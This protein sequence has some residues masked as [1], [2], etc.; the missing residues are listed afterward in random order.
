MNRLKALI[1]DGTALFRGVGSRLMEQTGFDVTIAETGSDGLQL[2]KSKK[3]DLIC[4]SYHL[5][6]MSGSEFCGQIRALSRYDFSPVLMLTGEDNP[7]ILKQALLSGA[8]DIFYK[9]DLFELENYLRRFVERQSRKLSGRVLFIED[10]R[11]LQEIMLDLLTDMGLDV[12]AYTHAEGA[13]Q[14]FE[15]SHYDLVI[16]D[17]MLEGAMSGI[18]LV[19]KIR[20]LHSE[21]GDVPIIAVSG[22][23]NVS[24]KIELFNLGVN[25]YVAKPIIH[26][27][28]KQRVFNNV[29]S[30]QAVLELRS[31]QKA[32]YSLA[33]L[34]ELTQ[35][36][37]RHA[38]REFSSKYFS[39]AI[40]FNR[41]LTMAVMDIDSFKEINRTQGHDKG[42]KVLAELGRWLKRFVRDEDMVA[43][44]SGDE[45]IFL[46]PDCDTETASALMKRLQKRL[47][48]FKPENIE[49]TVSI[50]IA[51]TQGQEN[52]NLNSLFELADGAMYQAKMAGRNCVREYHRDTDSLETDS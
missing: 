12:D 29:T 48:Q 50:G 8:T 44:W 14:A 3:F 31:Q 42:D 40:R 25:D 28:I 1:I 43:R 16:T 38:L 39:E 34:D 19:R 5:P 26:E 45:F 30:Y 10:S 32:L 4:C 46:L 24:R 21:R 18:S 27:E 20:R 13:W 2:A 36:F 49:L 15:S 37:N 41:P 23:D 9:K 52:N 22:F 51:S 6:D 33:M 11:V 47:S 7:R 17:I 35:L